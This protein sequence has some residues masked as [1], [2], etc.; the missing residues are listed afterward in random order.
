MHNNTLTCCLLARLFTRFNILLADNCD[1]PLQLTNFTNFRPYRLNLFT[2]LPCA[3]SQ[4][5]CFKRRLNLPER[6][7]THYNYVLCNT[8]V[9]CYET[10]TFLP[11]EIICATI[12]DLSN[13]QE[14]KCFLA[15][16][17]ISAL[18]PTNII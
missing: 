10:V 3:I 18:V 14:L 7:S 5:L 8:S 12:S 1:F 13:D 17:S 6:K 4:S 11:K 16:K 15:S 9:V 2:L